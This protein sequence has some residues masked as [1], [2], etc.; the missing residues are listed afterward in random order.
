[1]KKLILSIVLGGSGLFTALST[2][3]QSF[4]L[5]K[6]TV[7]SVVTGYTAGIGA[8][9]NT[10]GD[11]IQIVWKVVAHTLPN[12]WQAA[13]GICDNNNCYGNNVFGTSAV[14]GTPPFTPPGDVKT[15]FKFKGSYTSKLQADF[16][17]CTAG[18]P[19]YIRVEMTEGSTTKYLTY[20][21]TKFPT[22]VGNA[23]KTLK[24]VSIYP[25]PAH[26]VLNVTYDKSMGVKN[27]AIVN[28]IG[29]V[30]SYFKTTDDNSAKLS[31]DNLVSGV[32]FVNLIDA[33]G[34]TI[35]TRKFTAIN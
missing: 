5:E 15:T 29:K 34:H 32:Y 6:D 19:Y 31:T 33:Q 18:G 17:T 8:K 12:D 30:V 10:T 9:V 3:A 28:M 21:L 25:N 23:A 35:T 11:S 13:V 1:M 4:T 26:D 7:Y 27:I 14:P 2:H 22:S 24:E 20:A 16:T